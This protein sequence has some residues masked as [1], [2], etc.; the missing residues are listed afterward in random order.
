[1]KCKCSINSKKYRYCCYKNKFKPP[2][3]KIDDDDF[4][5]TLLLIF[6]SV[7]L[8][9]KN[10]LLSLPNDNNKPDNTLTNTHLTTNTFSTKTTKILS[11]TL[12]TLTPKP[13]Q[14]DFNL[15]KNLPEPEESTTSSTSSTTTS[16]SSSTKSTFTP[17]KTDN[18]PSKTTS[19]ELLKQP[20][21][22]SENNVSCPICQLE[23]TQ[24]KIEFY[25]KEH[26]K[27][28]LS[29]DFICN[30]L[31]INK[32]AIEFDNI[33]YKLT[34]FQ[35]RELIETLQKYI[36][37]YATINEIEVKLLELKNLLEIQNNILE[38]DNNTLSKTNKN[39]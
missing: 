13:T 32:N 31:K 14:P 24:I 5:S 28:P 29:K 20:K 19:L 3:K 12:T 1:M 30:R 9:I 27:N 35:I 17:T 2:N 37:K 26:I 16:N 34:N 25:L 8:K 23:L 22:T 18:I 11:T 38:I 21:P 33:F 39:L 15:P 36:E 6:S 7:F 4:Y 10:K